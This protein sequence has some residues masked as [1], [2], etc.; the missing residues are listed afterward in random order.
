MFY[1]CSLVCKLTYSESKCVF[2]SLK[3]EEAP[4]LLPIELYQSR[5]RVG[6]PVGCNRTGPGAALWGDTALLQM[7]L[8]L[9]PP[10]PTDCVVLH[11]IH[12]LLHFSATA[13]SER[14]RGK[15]WAGR[16]GTAGTTPHLLVGREG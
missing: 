1:S 5:D 3:S 15:S 12:C 2:Q 7:V 10:F 8:F 16:G 11:Q 6:V 14:V 9:I 4:A 13:R